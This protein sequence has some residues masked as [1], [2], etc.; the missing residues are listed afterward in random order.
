MR[1]FWCSLVLHGIF[2]S[3]PKEKTWLF[4][5][6]GVIYVLPITFKIR[7]GFHVRLLKRHEYRAKWPASHDSFWYWT[8]SIGLELALLSH[9]LI[10]FVDSNFIHSSGL[11]A[12]FQISH[13]KRTT[14]CGLPSSICIYDLNYNNFIRVFE[15][16]I[17]NICFRSIGVCVMAACECE[18][19]KSLILAHLTIRKAFL[20]VCGAAIWRQN[21]CGLSI[22][23]ATDPSWSNRCE[24]R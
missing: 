14:D 20:G 6:L 18:K 16:D 1:I 21:G 12:S 24:V 15:Y 4:W 9:L 10:Q 22:V 8:C 19:V 23:G 13:T 17:F 3:I 2:N 7:F 11:H 5:S